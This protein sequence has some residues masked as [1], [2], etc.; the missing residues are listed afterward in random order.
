MRMSFG[1]VFVFLFSFYS[2]IYIFGWDFLLFN[3]AMRNNYSF[4]IVKKYNIL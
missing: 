3:Q 2:Q 4:S 1:R